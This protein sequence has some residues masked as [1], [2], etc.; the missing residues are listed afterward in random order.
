MTSIREDLGGSRV[1]NCPRG[2]GF[3]VLSKRIF[4]TGITKGAFEKQESL[5]G[6]MLSL[7]AYAYMR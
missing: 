7:T 3:K 1:M 2:K 4:F 5:A 6:E